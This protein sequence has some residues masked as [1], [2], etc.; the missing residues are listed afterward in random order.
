[1]QTVEGNSVKQAE[2]SNRRKR[3][4]KKLLKRIGM[5]QNGTVNRKPHKVHFEEDDQFSLTSD[6]AS[7][8]SIPKTSRKATKEK[9]PVLTVD[10]GYKG[11]EQHSPRDP[12]PSHARVAELRISGTQKETNNTRLPRYIDHSVTD[13]D[14]SDRNENRYCS[15]HDKLTGY[16][17]FTADKIELSHYCVRQTTDDLANDLARVFHSRLSFNA[18]EALEAHG[19]RS[20]VCSKK[21]H[22][23]RSFS[24]VTPEVDKGYVPSWMDDDSKVMDRRSRLSK[25]SV[26]S[27]QVL[28]K[29]AHSVSDLREIGIDKTTHVLDFLTMNRET[30]HPEKSKNHARIEEEYLRLRKQMNVGND[31]SLDLSQMNTTLSSI[32]TFEGSSVP[33]ALLQD[34]TTA[35]LESDELGINHFRKHI[36]N[37]KQSSKKYKRTVRNTDI[38]QKQNKRKMPTRFI[39]IYES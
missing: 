19:F 39:P 34:Q 23:R 15:E 33:L 7:E 11:L 27:D 21:R 13:K 35:M 26:T 18:K 2:S 36:Q 4:R 32:R 20:S 16:D 29:K 25:S 22:R 37:V 14:D 30:L 6:R 24:D 3:L 31:T 38:A 10:K 28:K 8:S 5:V 9:I 12:V 1:M 17:V